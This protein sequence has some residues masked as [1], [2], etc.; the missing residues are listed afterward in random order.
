MFLYW[1]I[2]FCTA[3]SISVL[4]N[5]FPQYTLELGHIGVARLTPER[6]R[7]ERIVRYTLYLGHIGVARLTP[8]RSH[9]ERIVRY[10][11]YL[12]H[13]G[14]ARLTPERSHQ[15]RIVRYTLYLGHIGVARLT[16]EGS[17]QERIVRYTL[18]LGPNVT[19]YPE[20]YDLGN[21]HVLAYTE[22]QAS[23]D[24]HV[25]KAISCERTSPPEGSQ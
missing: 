12:G 8:E 21:I 16:P 7:Q 24:S 23:L 4:G 20:C 11:L 5:Q 15:E 25:A 2:N 6:S 18:Y 17:L 13:I 22:T 1:G 14:V 9:Q 19:T 3:E 10:T